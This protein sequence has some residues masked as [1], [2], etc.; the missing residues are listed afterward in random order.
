[1]STNNKPQRRVKR[2][3]STASILL[4]IF[5]FAVL[6]VIAVFVVAWN[7]GIRYLKVEYDDGSFI[8]FFGR[9]DDHGDPYT[10]KLY[11]ST[12]GT[13]KVDMESGRVEYSNGDVYEGQM[14]NL[15]REGSGKIVFASGDSYTG[16]FVADKI[17]GSGLFRYSNGDEYE[18]ALLDG[19]REGYGTYTWAD[20]SLYFGEFSND[21][22]N[23]AGKFIWA[24]G[25]VLTAEGS[26]RDSCS[27]PPSSTG[28][29]RRSVRRRGP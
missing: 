7:M 21:M 4:V 18:G 16:D 28:P 14:K 10:G 15:L 17:T 11:F 20:G 22:K 3:V 6:A 8:K 26:G 9:V 13:A 12:G 27:A 25:A 2:R 19:K 24:D 5:I 29:R 1:M 23:G